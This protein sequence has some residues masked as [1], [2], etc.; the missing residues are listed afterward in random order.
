MTINPSHDALRAFYILRAGDC[1]CMRPPGHWCA[2]SCLALPPPHVAQ[3][4]R[5]HGIL[6]DVVVC[7]AEH[8]QLLACGA[9][10]TFDMAQEHYSANADTSADRSRHALRP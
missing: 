1:A 5:V 10:R 9:G 7:A 4:A 6:L 2:A 3:I 8:D